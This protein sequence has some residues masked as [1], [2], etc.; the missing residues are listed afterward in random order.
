MNDT[1][2]TQPDTTT[3]ALGAMTPF[4]VSVATRLTVLGSDIDDLGWF[5][6]TTVSI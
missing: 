2:A 6:C 4:A 1:T 5:T 3:D